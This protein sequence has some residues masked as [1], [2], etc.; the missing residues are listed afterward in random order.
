MVG[1]AVL[2]LGV[3]TGLPPSASEVHFVEKPTTSKLQIQLINCQVIKL[4]WAPE[5][6]LKCLDGRWKRWTRLIDGGGRALSQFSV[7]LNSTQFDAVFFGF[8]L[9]K[10]VDST[11]C[12]VFLFVPPGSR[13]QAC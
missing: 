1:A 8:P 5:I 2:E 11:W 6:A 7:L 10:S 4:I 13:F 9:A 12:L 3:H